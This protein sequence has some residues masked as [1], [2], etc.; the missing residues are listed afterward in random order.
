LSTFN[1]FNAWVVNSSNGGVNLS[2]DT[3]KVMLTNT[4]PVATNSL[5][6]DISGNEVANGN[7]Y[8]TGGASVTGQ[9]WSQSGGIATLAGSLASPTWTASGSVGPF[10]YEVIY[11][12]TATSPLKPLIGWWDYGSSITLT[13]GQT[14]TGSIA[15]GVLTLQ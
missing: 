5:Y 10:R 13:S 3:L 4:L 1:K 8:T 12:A 15:S 6:G 9:S 11:D 7:G 2:T 14:F